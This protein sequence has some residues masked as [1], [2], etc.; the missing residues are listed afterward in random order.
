MLRAQLKSQAANAPLLHA[1]NATIDALEAGRHVAAGDLP[2]PLLAL[3]RPQL[4]GFLISAFAYDP[5]Q[6]L[7]GYARPLLVLQ[8]ERDQQIG[9]D[10]ARLLAQAAPHAQLAAA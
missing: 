3:F 10:D 2:R 5:V 8:G 4:Q 1:A 7:R 6:V 9:A